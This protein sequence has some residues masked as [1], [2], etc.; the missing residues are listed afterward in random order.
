M[1]NKNIVSSEDSR[2][3][4]TLRFPLVCLVVVIHSFSFIKGWEISELDLSNLS[5]ADL[6]SLFCISLSMTLAHIAVPVFL[7]ISGYLFFN[8]LQ[9]WN[10]QT[11]RSKLNKRV[12][13]LLVPY[14]AWNSIYIL[15][16]VGTRLGGVILKG[17]PISRIVEWWDGHNGILMYYHADSMVERI[18]WLGG[19]GMFSFPILVPMW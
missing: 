12:T 10:W 15:Q 14:L 4:H 2:L 11:Y 5:G 1:D 18:N 7:L 16:A 13:T 19:E 9:T 17:K 6:Y 3:I 8:G